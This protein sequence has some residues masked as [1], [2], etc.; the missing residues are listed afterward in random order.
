MAVDREES[1]GPRRFEI[2]TP[3][4]PYGTRAGPRRFSC[5][6]PCQTAVT[7]R[8][9]PLMLRAER[10]AFYRAKDMNRDDTAAPLRP[11]AEAPR[12]SPPRI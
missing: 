10:R 4:L 12:A 5:L 2:A 11:P 3:L 6:T 9:I 7:Y 1:G 8:A